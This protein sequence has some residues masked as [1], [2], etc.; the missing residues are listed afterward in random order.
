MSPKV[1]KSLEAV[2][3]SN[4]LINKNNAFSNALLVVQKSNSTSLCLL[5]I[6]IYKKGDSNRT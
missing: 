3:E 2:R 6:N 1:D 4:T 5:K